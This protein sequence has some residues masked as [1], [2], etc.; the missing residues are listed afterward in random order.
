MPQFHPVSYMEV[1]CFFQMLF[2]GKKEQKYEKAHN[3]II[4]G[5]LIFYFAF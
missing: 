2:E 3:K 1:K 5:F 4:A